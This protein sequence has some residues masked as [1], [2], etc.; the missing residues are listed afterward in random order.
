MTRTSNSYSL[1]RGIKLSS[2][3]WKRHLRTPRSMLTGKGFAWF[4]DAIVPCAAK[5]F[6]STF[7][8]VCHKQT[9]K[10]STH[11]LG[12][13]KSKWKNRGNCV[14]PV[15]E[16]LCGRCWPLRSWSCCSCRRWSSTSRCRAP[17]G[18]ADLHRVPPSPW[19]SP[20]V[21]CEHW[22]KRNTPPRQMADI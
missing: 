6:L 2:C 4:F 9:R 11:S 20:R 19:S 10:L 16:C 8:C 12:V 7:G 14:L 5:S 1:D 15:A 3:V 13:M 18:F 22:S 17:Q 21:A